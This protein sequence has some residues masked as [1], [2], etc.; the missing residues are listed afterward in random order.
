ME[1]KIHQKTRS[2]KLQEPRSKDNQH[3]PE[4]PP[5]SS[6]SNSHQHSVPEITVKFSHH[7]VGS[8]SNLVSSIMCKEAVLVCQERSLVSLQPL[9]VPAVQIEAV[10][11]LSQG[12]WQPSTLKMKDARGESYRFEN[13]QLYEG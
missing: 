10:V 8:P 4:S 12:R 9:E 5:E 11:A 1:E 3:H 13:W 2:S 7:R 6:G